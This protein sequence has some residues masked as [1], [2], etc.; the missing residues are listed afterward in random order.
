MGTEE[1]DGAEA[2]QRERRGE[3]EAC[4]AQAPG[5]GGPAHKAGQYIKREREREKKRER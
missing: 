5:N 1:T 4:E 2:G 3:L